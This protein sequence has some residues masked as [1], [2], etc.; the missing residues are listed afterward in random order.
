[1]P[2]RR[3]LEERFWEK[4]DRR[5]PDDCW[6]WQAGVY[7][8]GYG[9]INEGGRGKALRAHRLSYEMANGPIPEG[10]IVL[11]KCDNPPCVNPRHLR[12]GT[13]QDNIAD[14][15]SKG[16]DNRG[17][18]VKMKLGEANTGSK[19]TEEQVREI[20]ALCREGYT[21]TVIAARYGISQ[22]GVSNIKNRKYWPHVEDV[23]EA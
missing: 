21:Q 12:L 1:M 15:I 13:H 7:D 17:P 23:P 18:G 11:H 20:R 3:S 2:I 10:L 6:E 22:S 8:F 16:R 9:K 5:G 19:L 14:M 4:V